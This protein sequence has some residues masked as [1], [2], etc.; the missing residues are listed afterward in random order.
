MTT[1]LHN[2]LNKTLKR[3]STILSDCAKGASYAIKQ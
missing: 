3:L 1:S 2:K